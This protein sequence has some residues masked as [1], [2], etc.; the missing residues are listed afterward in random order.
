MVLRGTVDPSGIGIEEQFARIEKEP[1]ERVPRTI[2]PET[3]GGA[4]RDAPDPHESHIAPARRHR[5]PHGFPGGTRG[6][7]EETELHR[8]SGGRVDREI[9]RAVRA[10]GRPEGIG[11]AREQ[12]EV[13]KGIGDRHDFALGE[14]GK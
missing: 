9:H 5:D 12:V 4:R 7:H 2:D 6:I 11:L 3:I 1:R 13:G 8:G 10:P 14:R